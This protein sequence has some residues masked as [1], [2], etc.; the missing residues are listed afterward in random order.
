MKWLKPILK[1]KGFTVTTFAGRLGVAPS[2]VNQWIRGT[3]EPRA[4]SIRQACEILN[5]SADELLKVESTRHAG[6]GKPLAID[7]LNAVTR[8]GRLDAQGFHEWA[9]RLR[10]QRGGKLSN[11]EAWLREIAEVISLI[12]LTKRKPSKKKKPP[13]MFADD[14]VVKQLR[15][16]K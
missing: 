6:L 13:V 15:L 12:E 14:K 10:V 8:G 4:S 16:F 2:T 9:T 11:E 3:F 5:V 7:L 1:E